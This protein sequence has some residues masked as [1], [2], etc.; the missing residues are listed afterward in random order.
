[1]D[2][3]LKMEM[4]NKEAIEKDLAQLET[5]DKQNPTPKLNAEIKALNN[6][7]IKSGEKLDAMRLLML[8]YCSGLQMCLNS[9][10]VEDGAKS[11]QNDDQPVVKP[12]PAKT[13]TA[14]KTKSSPL[15]GLV[16]RAGTSVKEKV[17]SIKKDFGRK[18]K[19]SEPKD[20][21]QFPPGGSNN[22]KE[23]ATCPVEEFELL[24]ETDL[25]KSSRSQSSGQVEIRK[26]EL[27]ML[28]QVYKAS[29]HATPEGGDLPNTTHPVVEIKVND[30]DISTHNPVRDTIDYKEP[31]HILRE[32]LSLTRSNSDSGLEICK[33]LSLSPEDILRY[34]GNSLPRIL[35][36]DNSDSDS[37][38]FV[39]DSSDDEVAVSES[40]SDVEEE[41]V[42][43]EVKGIA[44]TDDQDSDSSVDQHRSPTQQLE[45]F[46][47]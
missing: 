21:S 16:R 31:R 42:A 5:S 24:R 23:V 35:V 12:E 4:Q 47:V 27:D 33:M 8:Q 28:Q 39:V 3:Q 19:S 20:K 36:T 40:C 15:S 2:E 43:V 1:M 25:K 32:Q 18:T 9:L 37:D 13:D 41:P 14:T 46:Q 29:D 26:T 38:F 7:A 44:K 17:T 22:N 30:E 34:R 10:E 45:T 11:V 6:K